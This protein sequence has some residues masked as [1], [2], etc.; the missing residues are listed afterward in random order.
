MD[1]IRWTMRIRLALVALA[2]AACTADDGDPERVASLAQPV[3]VDTC[4]AGPTVGNGGFETGTLEGWTRGGRV[5]VL[6]R[7][8]SGA[9]GARLARA[10]AWA[11]H[12]SIKQAVHIPAAADGTSSLSFWIQPRC[13]AAPDYLAV[14]VR[15]PAGP[16]LA[17]LMKECASATV[18][19]ERSFDLS[20]WAGQDVVLRFDAWD[21]GVAETPS[22]AFLDDVKVLTEVAPP[23]VVI[24][25][26]ASGDNLPRRATVSAAAQTS[27][28]TGLDRI[29]LHRDG[30]LAAT[31][32]TS[33]ASVEIDLGASGAHTILARAFDDLGGMAEW[34]VDVTSPCSAT[35]AWTA[36]HVPPGLFPLT[37]VIGANGVDG[38]GI[39]RVASF[40]GLGN[41]TDARDARTGAALGSAGA[42]ADRPPLVFESGGVTYLFLASSD[43]FLYRKQMVAGVL[44]DAGARDMRRPSCPGD[45][46][47][48]TPV[49]VDKALAGP[50]YPWPGD[51]LV[52][53]TA[54]GCADT[55]RNRIIALDPAGAMDAPPLWVFNADG[56]IKVDSNSGCAVDHELG[57]VYCGTHLEDAASGQSSLFALDVATGTLVWSRNMGSLISRPV[58][59][60]VAR[61][62]VVANRPGSLWALDPDSPGGD[63]L[64]GP[65]AIAGTG[66]T[67]ERDLWVDTRGVVAGRVF[68]VDTGGTLHAV[69]AGSGS[70]LWQLDAP[71]GELFVSQ[72]VVAVAAAGSPAY[73]YVGTDL[74]R[75]L[76][77]RIGST[78][79]I[80]GWRAIDEVSGIDAAA[81]LLSNAVL[82]TTATYA[83]R[84]CAPFENGAP[85]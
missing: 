78:Y 51:L 73:L 21:D 26:P 69:S 17:T 35:P 62:L 12:S 18:W 75:I 15:S 81:G 34:S 27:A 42:A 20:P 72:P 84:F 39:P 11:G 58:L 85:Y 4:G 14:E 83:K 74:G 60:P 19:Q 48:A 38:D 33:P 71:T 1:V 24:T 76:E 25:E 50:G 55:T 41:R 54:D 16:R 8:H 9:Y 10:I 65:L 7:H 77:V 63:V 22:Y 30:V 37:P 49:R 66:T 45:G 59:D 36:A 57:R 64:W 80:S 32:F 56:A 53:A 43:G 82:G 52:V 79:T 13:A 47:S 31:S 23:S 67:I 46:L 61:R 28:C 5:V 68:A 40:L 29:E 3:V 6:A 70:V 44:T 2:V